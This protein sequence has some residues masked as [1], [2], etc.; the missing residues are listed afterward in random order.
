MSFH[1]MNIGTHTAVIPQNTAV[2]VIGSFY[3]KPHFYFLYCLLYY[4]TLF[5][6]CKRASQIGHFRVLLG[7]CFNTSLRAKPFM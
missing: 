7:F 5:F 3:P 2:K 1:S 4:Y 6:T